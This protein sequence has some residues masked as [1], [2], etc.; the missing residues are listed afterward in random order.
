MATAKKGSAK[1]PPK[2][3]KEEAKTEKKSGPSRRLEANVVARGQVN[4]RQKAVKTPRA[5]NPNPSP[6]EPKPAPEEPLSVGALVKK[7]L[8]QEQD[9]V[10][11]FGQK[12]TAERGKNASREEVA[13]PPKKS[14]QELAQKQRE[15]SVAEFFAKN[16]HL[17]GFDSPAKSLLM[18]IKEAVDNALDACEEAGILPTISVAIQETGDDKFRIAVEDNGPGIIKQQIPKIFGKLLYGSKFNSFRQSRGAQ[19]LGISA[20][21]MYGQITTGKPAAITSRASLTEGATYCELT[22]DT[23]T[24]KPEIHKEKNNVE[25][26][27]GTGTRVEIEMTGLYKKGRH[28]VDSYLQQTAIANPHAEISYQA[29]READWLIWKRQAKQLPKEAVP[30]KPHPHGLELGL[31]L[32]MLRDS[33]RPTLEQFLLEDL[34]RVN[35]KI[36]KEIAEKSKLTLSIN[37][38]KIQIHQAEVLY[39]SIQDVK[40]PPPPTNCLSPIG[41]ELLRRGLESGIEGAEFYAAL[42]RPPAVYRGNPFQVEV[43]IAFGGKL[44]GDEP[45]D[46]YRFAN[47]VPLLY[48]QSACGIAKSVMTA[49][50]KAYGLS[51]P[52]GA[53]PI[54]P[55]VL[56]IHIASVWVPFTSESKEAIAHYPEILREVRLAVQ[57]CGRLLGAHIR[58]LK[59]FSSEN[60]KRSYIDKYIPHIGEALREIL[61]FPVQ[62]KE[63]IIETLRDTLER[64]RREMLPASMRR[65][66]EAEEK[67]EQMRLVLAQ[68]VEEE[69]VPVE[70]IE[71]K[72]KKVEPLAKSEEKAISLAKKAAE[73][74]VLLPVETKAKRAKPGH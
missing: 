57:D 56:V 46:L 26:R 6:K 27:P 34:S 31:F 47:R 42:T 37:P 3:S 59:R 19:G 25:F 7:E 38:Q 50:W 74:L 35:D 13:G 63:K 66:E 72:T 60:K 73:A 18:A 22:L 24:N 1:S 64:G 40:V 51:Q 39:Q 8:S 61:G 2:D 62:E 15:I 9:S 29:P 70:V 23:R 71:T 48:Q 10:A 4:E 28:S 5:K 20:A 32:Q 11:R 53:L 33:Q 12:L 49:G 65:A 54:G 58:K 55:L 41:E 52:K 14:A 43:G 44:P 68:S 36:A 16:R 69:I 30:I 67:A 21:V 45:C 17:L